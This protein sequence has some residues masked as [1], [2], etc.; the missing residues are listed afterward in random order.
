MKNNQVTFK[1]KGGNLRIKATLIKQVADGVAIVEVAE[2]NS[3]S[4]QTIRGR[5][6]GLY[7]GRIILIELIT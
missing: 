6:S 4:S 2:S 5:I 1:A 7:Q 3:S